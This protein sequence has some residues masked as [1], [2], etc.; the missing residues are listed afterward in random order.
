[1]AKKFPMALLLVSIFLHS[2]L[3]KGESS[4]APAL[5]VFGD[6]LSD[7]GNNNLL[8]TKAKV[9]YKPY[10]VDFPSGATG[11]FTNGKTMVDFIAQSLGLPFIPAYSGFSTTEKNNTTSGVNYASGAAG[12]LP[13]TG[14]A[15]GEI[16]CL[17]KQ[18]DYFKETIRKHLSRIYSKPLDRA[19]HL[20]KSIFYIA[21]GSNDYINNYLKPER[22][23][24]SKGYTP[25]QFADLLVHR[26]R[27]HIRKL[28]SLGARKFVVFNIGRLGCVPAI[29]N[30]ANPKPS[31]PCVEDVNNLVKLYNTKLPSMIKKLDK[32][33]SGSTFVRGDAYN[34]GKNSSEAGFTAAQ[35]VCCKV[36]ADTGQCR[37]DSTPCKNRTQ[38]LFWDAYHPTEIANHVA[39]SDCYSGPSACVPM[40]IKQLAQYSSKMCLS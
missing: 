29:V 32:T 2:L 9:N 21:I 4:L 40:N 30:T 18:I 5:Y 33:L 3:V 23:G 37:Q 14:T 38:V 22:Y 8:Q 13:E 10:G 25:Q 11:R 26:L 27:Q 34:M 20:S 16:L 15:M 31:T 39:A 19:K 1:M 12:I 36:N 35:T 24:T 17:D 6:S 28:Y 7:S